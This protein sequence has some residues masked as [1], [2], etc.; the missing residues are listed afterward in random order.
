MSDNTGQ[1]L[2]WILHFAVIEGQAIVSGNYRGTL[3]E[4]IRAWASMRD[5]GPWWQARRFALLAFL[6]WLVAHVVLPAGSF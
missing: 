5:K 4:R 2:L 3:T 6:A 1:W